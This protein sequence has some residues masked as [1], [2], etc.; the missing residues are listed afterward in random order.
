MPPTYSQWLDL[1]IGNN[2]VCRVALEAKSI[3]LPGSP[4]ENMDGDPLWIQLDSGVHHEYFGYKGGDG[5]FYWAKVTAHVTHENLR[6]QVSYKLHYRGAG[7]GPPQSYPEVPGNPRALMYMDAAGRVW[8]A[9]ILTSNSG[10]TP[11]F[12]I[13][14]A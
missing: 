12:Q 5:Q 3:S 4:F 10:E 1:V 8:N 9:T 14:P 13:E 6:P 11:T 2:T 7:L